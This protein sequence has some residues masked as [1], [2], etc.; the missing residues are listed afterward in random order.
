M[1]DEVEL[2]HAPRWE[3][4]ATAVLYLLVGVGGA[5]MPLLALYPEAHAPTLFVVG[6][7]LAL[8]GFVV[9]VR[10]PRVGISLRDESMT[11]VGFLHT[12]TIPRDVITAVTDIATVEW[13]SADGRRRV[14][15]LGIL[16]PAYEDDGTR[17]AR[18]WR[19]R[20]EALVRVREW[21]ETRTGESS[22]SKVRGPSH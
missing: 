17:F 13:R 1:S 8:I 22:P 7:I 3:R 15:G 6:G 20:R 18:F 4:I 2:L 5:A 11:Y 16:R 9:G 19:W 14:T 10:A 21:A 12:R